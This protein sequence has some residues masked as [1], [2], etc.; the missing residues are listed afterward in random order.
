M[1][2][3]IYQ[4]GDFFVP[5]QDTPLSKDSIGSLVIALPV[6]HRGGDLIV[7]HREDVQS[8]QF[9]KELCPTARSY[10]Y[11]GDTEK[12]LKEGK[13]SLRDDSDNYHSYGPE[14]E[15]Q[16]SLKKM[17]DGKKLKCGV[18]LPVISYAA[19]Y[20]DCV[21]EIKRVTGGLRLTLSYQL[22]R[23]D[24]EIDVEGEGVEEVAVE[25]LKEAEEKAQP[26]MEEENDEDEEEEDEEDEEKEVDDDNTRTLTREE[27]ELKLKQNTIPELKEYCRRLGLRVTG[28]KAVLVERLVDCERLVM[29]SGGGS[30]DGSNAG[31][32]PAAKYSPL[33]P[34]TS[35][36]RANLF[37]LALLQS[38]VNGDVDGATIGFPCYHLYEGEEDLPKLEGFKGLKLTAK[39]LK[40]LRGA[41]AL[42]TMVAVNAGFKV[43]LLR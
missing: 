6:A 7:K 38:L 33:N 28:T 15:K 18:A 19:F 31:G 4:E 39:D 41:D 25:V 2:L 29:K 27:R 22:L 37:R 16:K 20:G 3:N 40:R 26:A 21:H 14:F 42:M 23:G 43:S 12:S 30:D 35:S 13:Y 24:G 34:D 36:A 17:I 11:G 10:Y 5:H 9:A 8:F 32:E 1:K